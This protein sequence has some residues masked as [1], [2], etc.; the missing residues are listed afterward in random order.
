MAPLEDRLVLRQVPLAHAP[1]RP[2][3]IPKTR[4]G[5]L[6]RVAMHLADP[7][8]VVVPSPG[9]LRPRVLHRHADPTHPGEPAVAPPL[10]GGDRLPLQRPAADDLFQ[11]LTGGAAENLRAELARLP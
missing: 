3:E 8:A 5:A 4:P 1:E 10:V 7:V 6:H 11:R 2:Q 9:R